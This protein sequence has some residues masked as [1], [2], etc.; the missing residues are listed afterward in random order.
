MRTYIVIA[1]FHQERYPLSFCALAIGVSLKLVLCRRDIV[2]QL[3]ICKRP[4]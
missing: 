2:H 4:T 1:I 3:S